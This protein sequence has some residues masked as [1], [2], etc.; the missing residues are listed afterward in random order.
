[1]NL[2][3]HRAKTLD[4][5]RLKAIALT[6]GITDQQRRVATVMLSNSKLT[7]ELDTNDKVHSDMGNLL[8]YCAYTRS[9]TRG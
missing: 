6:T 1:M 3:E 2:F 9:Q 7:L 4:A 5:I 8:G